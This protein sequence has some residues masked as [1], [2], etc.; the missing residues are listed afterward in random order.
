MMLAWIMAEAV[1]LLR[2]SIQGALA[3]NATGRIIGWT[4]VAL[5]LLPLAFL[6]RPRATLAGMAVGK[7]AAVEGERKRKLASHQNDIY[8]LW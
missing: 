4:A 2:A 5:L 7:L 8:P 1:P 6:I 3:E